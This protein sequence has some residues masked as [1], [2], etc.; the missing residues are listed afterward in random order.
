[1]QSWLRK[2][3]P[4]LTYCCAAL[5]TEDHPVPIL[6][7]HVNCH[8]D[9]RR[10][11]GEKCHDHHCCHLNPLSPTA[12]NWS[13][14]AGC[15][16]KPLVRRRA[17]WHPGNLELSTCSA[18]NTETGPIITKQT[19][20]AKKTWIPLLN[21]FATF[22]L[23]IWEF[24]PH[25]TNDGF[26]DLDSR[27]LP[28][29][30]YCRVKVNSNA[31]SIN[32]HFST[33]PKVNYQRRWKFKSMDFSLVTAWKHQWTISYSNLAF[34]ENSDLLKMLSFTSFVKSS[35]CQHVDEFVLPCS[36]PLPGCAI[37]QKSSYTFHIQ[38]QQG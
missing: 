16:Q 37:H 24:R 7:R 27:V 28:L 18:A 19:I 3:V 4:D 9:Q 15:R 31:C 14:I 33:S 22:F 10:H 29:I 13:S 25:K 36:F 34:E 32:L 20:A 6:T 11:D 21:P 38:R 5:V 30:D 2:V 12:H 35:K 26:P 1:M 8:Q 17:A 23:G